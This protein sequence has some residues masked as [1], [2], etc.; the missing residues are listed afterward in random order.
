MSLLLEP[1]TLRQL[2]L[3]NRIAVSPMCQY[4]SVDGLANDWHLVHLGSRA[5]GG[6]GV[7]FTEAAAVTPEGR[8]SPNC[9]GLWNNTQAEALAPIA[10]TRMTEDILPPEVFKASDSLGWVYFRL[11]QLDEAL[12]HLQRAYFLYPSA[13]IAAHLGEVLWVRGERDKARDVWRAGRDKDPNDTVLVDT[14]KR[15]AQTF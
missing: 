5:V 15:F 9:T 3:P 12:R 2:T 4:S 1:F 13:E 7:V 14:L 10:A 11:G 6:A 8:I